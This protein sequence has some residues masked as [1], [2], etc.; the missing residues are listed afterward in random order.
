MT[1]GSLFSGNLSLDSQLDIV[2]QRSAGKHYDKL[3]EKLNAIFYPKGVTPNFSQ[4]QEKILSEEA[5]LLAENIVKNAN[6]ILGEGPITVDSKKSINIQSIKNAIKSAE[7][8]L[9]TLSSNKR[10]TEIF[11][12]YLKEVP[13]YIYEDD[14]LAGFYGYAD[15][16]SND[17]SCKSF[18]KKKALTDFEDILSLELL[19]KVGRVSLDIRRSGSAVIDLCNIA[20]GKAEMYFE[21]FLSPW[22]YAGGYLIVTEAGGIVTDIKPVIFWRLLSLC[23]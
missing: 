1:L 14:L 22:D 12:Y 11:K 20:S 5:T 10:Q 15:N 23:L 17:F 8:T 13:I 18:D 9:S 7:E 19:N 3:E 16:F 6:A 4:M 2:R 21:L